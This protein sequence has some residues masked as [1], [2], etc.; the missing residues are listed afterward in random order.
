MRKNERMTLIENIFEINPCGPWSFLAEEG[1]AKNKTDDRPSVT[2]KATVQP[3]SKT[4]FFKATER[5]EAYRWLELMLLS[6]FVVHSGLPR[7]TYKGD[8]FEV[9]IGSGPD[10]LAPVPDWH[11]KPAI[12]EWLRLKFKI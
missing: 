8:G 10:G 4:T 6:G 2:L 3:N 5:A 12:L 1:P 7:T 9:V 11:N